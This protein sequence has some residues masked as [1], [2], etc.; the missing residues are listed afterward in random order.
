[1]SK[2]ED[3]GKTAPHMPAIKIPAR[4]YTEQIYKKLSAA[5]WKVY[6]SLRA[7]ANNMGLTRARMVSI[8]MDTGLTRTTVCRTCISLQEKGAILKYY[9]PDR[10]TM[11]M[12]FPNDPLHKDV[13]IFHT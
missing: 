5:E 4:I 6:F 8:K 1:M 13:W 2:K 10:N 11:K 9:Q 12:L 7:H 3:S